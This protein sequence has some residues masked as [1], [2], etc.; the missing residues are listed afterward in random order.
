MFMAK[1]YYLSSI[2]NISEDINLHVHIQ[3]INISN[4]ET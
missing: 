3:G 1:D 2:S 4:L